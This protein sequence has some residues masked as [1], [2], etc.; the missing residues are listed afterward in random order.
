M[1][2]SKSS[3][4]FT[5]LRIVGKKAQKLLERARS[6]AQNQGK[7]KSVIPPR[8]EEQDQIL[9]HLSIMS[10]VKATLAIVCITLAILAV[11]H[12]RGKIILLLLGLFVAAV[13]DP[14][15]Q[16]MQRHGIPRGIAILF[17]YVVALFLVFFLLFSF[18]PII[19]AQL[20]QIALFISSEFDVFISNPKITLPIVSAETNLRLT[21]LVQSTMQNLSI[22]EFSDALQRMGQTLSTAA[23]GSVVFAAQLAGSVLNFFINLIVVLVFAFFIQ[24]EKEKI[25]QWVLSFMPERYRHYTNSKSEAIHTKIGQWAR[26][27]LL[28]MISIAILTFVALIILQMPYALTLA[29]LAGFCEFIPVVGPLIAAIPAVI[30]ALTQKGFL[31]ALTV[32]GVFYVIQWCENN[33]LV[34]LIMRRAVGLSPIAILFAML[35]GISFPDT[36]HPVLGVM[37]AIPATTILALFLEDWQKLHRR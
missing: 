13:I 8:A 11:Y 32:A 22:T 4:A 19:A 12:L 34:P 29:A 10:V 5:S 3:N 31:W 20:Q 30:I 16:A 2:H 21:H 28:L 15:V 17:Q 23:Q 26:G 14:G 27:E 9:V 25:L 1:A 33:L 6:A 37:L 35:V 18:I 7:T 36:I 24:L